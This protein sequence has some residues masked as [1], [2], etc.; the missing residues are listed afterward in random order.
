[1]TKSKAYSIRQILELEGE[2]PDSQEPEVLELKEELENKS[3]LELLKM[4][5]DLRENV[6]PTFLSRVGSCT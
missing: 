2:D 6:V 3:V 1:M 4:I 5:Q